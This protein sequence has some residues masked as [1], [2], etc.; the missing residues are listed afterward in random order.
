MKRV[1][2]A[3]AILAGTFLAI[4]P[5][6]SNS[7]HFPNFLQTDDKGKELSIVPDRASGEMKV[8]FKADKASNA[9]FEVLD[10]NG[11]VVLQQTAQFTTGI[12][13]VPI[14][15]STKLKEGAYTLT[16]VT[17]K[18]TYHSRFLIWK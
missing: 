16:L 2:L 7:G 18:L 15:N 6:F 5:V 1:F 14:V 9:T 4:Q 11:K 13:N 17:N 12:N 10:E 8:R 3:A